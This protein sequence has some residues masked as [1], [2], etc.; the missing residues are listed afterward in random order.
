MIVP[1]KVRANMAMV[2][3][4]VQV[5]AGVDLLVSALEH[6]PSLSIPKEWPFGMSL[7]ELRVELIVCEEFYKEGVFKEMTKHLMQELSKARTHGY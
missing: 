7:D 3:G 5:R 4:L 6:H 1:D 2:L